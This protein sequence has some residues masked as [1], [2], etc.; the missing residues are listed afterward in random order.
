MSCPNCDGTMECVVNIETDNY[1]L[2][3]C[4]R[5][6]TSKDGKGKYYT[7]KLIK[8]LRQFE[9]WL[10]DYTK[11]AEY[12]ETHK[13]LEKYQLLGIAESINLPKDRLKGY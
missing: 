13:I 2:Y 9:S 11:D 5:C 10:I 1:K 4:P 7:P 3:Q 8:K 6:G 12:D